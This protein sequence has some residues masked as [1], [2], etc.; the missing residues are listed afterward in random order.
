[1][2]TQDGCLAF[3]ARH[4]LDD[5]LFRRLLSVALSTGGDACDLFFQQRTVQSLAL[6]DRGITR[7]SRSE[8]LGVGIR[9]SVGDAC[10]YAFC[11][12][13]EAD[14]MLEAARVAAAISRAGALLPPT[15]ITRRELPPTRY[16]I[17]ERWQDITT[18]Q[19]LPL[20][21]RLDR[22]AFAADARV[23][24][25]RARFADIDSEV[26]I[27]DAEGR[28]VFDSQPMSVISCACVVQDGSR[29]EEG[30][31]SFGGRWGFATYDDARL[32]SV[33]D[34]AS[35]RALRLLD[36]V[37]PAAGE[38]PVVLGAGSSGILLHEAVGH[39]LEADFN[40][41][42]TSIYADALGES[43]APPFVSIVD[44][45][46]RPNLRGSLNVDDEGTPGQ[47]TV[48]VEGGILRTYMHDRL[49]ARHAG[50]ASTGN[51][52][53]QS[54][55]HPVLP[56]M[57]TTYMEA[58]PHD[59]EEIVRS[60]KRGIYAESFS[61]GQVQIGAGDFTFYIKTGYLIED[62]KLTAPI[63]DVNL[64]GNGPEVLRDVEMVADDLVLD[65]G[66]W[67]C[68]KEGQSVPVSHGMPTVKVRAMTVGGVG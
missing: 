9:V 14:A 18:A 49:S 46:T 31:A 66:G 55:R 30:T 62:G 44:D 59:K 50:I 64:I 12:E 47:R 61:N 17:G 3:E 65:T 13:L 8:D 45:A 53:R 41:K 1:M 38:M 67:T 32:D 40:R 19:R 52:R 54:F 22:R 35:S 15:A 34:E 36:A 42:G 51:G 29:R 58:G 11:E 60:V 33:A 56:R 25:V 5:D 26:L 2:T 24:K 43:I 28:K 10:G 48:L 68:G 27:V 6:E 4:G 39:G 20:L 23:Q 63:K 21:D 7:A 37:T 16:L 57:R